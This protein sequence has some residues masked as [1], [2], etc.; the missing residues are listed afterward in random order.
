MQRGCMSYIYQFVLLLYNTTINKI[1][2]NCL[3][4]MF[5]RMMGAKLSSNCI[6]FRRC[7]LIKPL[8]L[9]VGKNSS[10]GWF[11]LVD[12]RGGI[13]I[14]NN[15]T[16]ASYVKMVTAKHDIE[17]PMFSASVHPIII[18]DYAWICTGSTIL[19]GV[20]VGKGAVVAAGAVVTKDVPPMTVVAGVPA[21]EVKKRMTEPT[22]ED[23]MK[24]ALF[25]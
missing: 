11:S 20:T 7:E 18:E 23:D 22:F 1:P 2:N 4:K 5:L 12:A 19:G 3:R 15:V 25:N 10:I 16:V 6:I 24:W 9:K 14:G 13:T 17:D 21:R 8:G